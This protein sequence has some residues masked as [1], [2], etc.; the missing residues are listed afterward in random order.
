MFLTGGVIAGVGIATASF[1]LVMASFGRL[2]PPEKRSWAFGIATAAGSLGQFIFAPLGQAF[3]AAFG[4][5]TALMLIGALVLL[6]IPLSI[7][8]ARKGA[9]PA[10]R[11]GRPARHDIARCRRQG[12]RPFELY[13]AHCRLL[14]LRLS[15]RFRHDPSSR[16]S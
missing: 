9:T 3:I 15:D 7:P 10:A 1:T 13:P 14:R 2:V 5:E 6:I 12:L 11:R 4:W 8:S 16:L